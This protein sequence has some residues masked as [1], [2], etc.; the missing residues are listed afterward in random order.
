MLRRKAPKAHLL[1]K[2]SPKRKRGFR[3][4]APVA[5]ANVKTVKK[6]LGR[7]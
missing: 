4:D 3:A 2:K 1:G 7:G 5:E 6:M